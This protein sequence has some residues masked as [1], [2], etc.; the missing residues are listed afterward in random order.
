MKSGSRWPVA[1]LLLALLLVTSSSAVAQ[2][3]MT[4]P[5]RIPLDPARET[6]D[7]VVGDDTLLTELA[8]SSDQQTLGLGYRN[9]LKA[10]SAMLFV[11]DSAAPRTF[12]MKGMRFC[13]DIVWIEAGEIAGAAE[14][15]CPD[16]AGTPD[17]DRARVTSPVP[18]TYVLEV[19]AGWL[20]A[21]GYG[22]GTEVTI[23][24]LPVG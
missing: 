5:W 1:G 23:P 17:Q 9:E 16:P 19:N 22:V 3:P 6:V 4:P 7:V 13:L 2:T 21:H 8:I 18:V 15:I 12:W 10:D 20:E 24:E 11:N 14:N